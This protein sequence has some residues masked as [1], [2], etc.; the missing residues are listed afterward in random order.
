[1]SFISPPLSFGRKAH[2]NNKNYNHNVLEQDQQVACLSSTTP[3]PQLQD[4]SAL[5]IL[6]YFGTQ[7]NPK[8]IIPSD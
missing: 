8:R 3:G 2:N 7:F 4:T 1:L 5:I 6:S